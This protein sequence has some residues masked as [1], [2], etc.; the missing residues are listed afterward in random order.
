MRFAKNITPR[1]AYTVGLALIA[2]LVTL[3]LVGANVVVNR[4]EISAVQINLAGRQRMLSQRIAWTMSRLVSEELSSR[5]EQSLRNVLGACVDLM[6]RSHRALNARVLEEMNDV[7]GAGASCLSPDATSKTGLPAERFALAEPQSLAVFT[8]HAWEVALGLQSADATRTFLA[9]FEEPL[10]RLLEQLDR[11]TRDAQQK[12]VAQIELMLSINWILI[13]ALVL[14]ELVLIFQ[15][16]ARSVERSLLD[17]E[18]ANK[19]LRT[20]ENR[21]QDFA[22]TAAHQFWE[23]DA[24]HRFTWIDS[25]EPSARLRGVSCLVGRY[26]WDIN[27]VPDG[28]QHPDWESLRVAFDERQ[29]F[30]GFD[31]P[32]VDAAGLTRWWRLNGRPIYSEDNQFLGYRGTS[33]EI[34]RERETEAQLRVS[35]RMRA[36]GQLT[37]G[38]A[39]DFNNI[40]TVI[41]GS[42]DLIPL[43]ASEKERNKSVNA[44]KAGVFRGTSLVQRLL[45][46]GQNQYLHA[47]PVNVAIFL[48]ELEDLL[49]R[50][51]GEDFNVG[52]VLP[53]GNH[54][55]LADPNQLGDACLNIA[56]NARDAASPGGRLWIE[57]KVAEQKRIAELSGNVADSNRYFCISFRDNGP[58]ISSDMREKIFEPFFTSKGVGKGTG[59]GLSMVYGFVRQSNGYIDVQSVE[60]EGATFE[61]F[62]PMVSEQEETSDLPKNEKPL[63]FG[64]RALLV[65]DNDVLRGVT[66]RHLESMGMEVAESSGGAGALEQLEHGGPFDILILDI[67]LPGAIDG[68]EIFRRAS[69]T[70]PGIK[71]LFCSGLV[72]TDR[73]FGDP[74]DIPGFLLT[75]PF[76]LEEL[77]DAV[78]TVLAESDRTQSDKGSSRAY[79]DESAH[80]ADE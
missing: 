56:L 51:L 29:T 34:T 21:L 27:G 58:G 36:L 8:Q 2:M 14:G 77:A 16:M 61:I 78:R 39:H 15:P 38:V 1:R 13:I 32:V 25:S 41:Q 17:L 60:G 33:L 30:N 72:G 40:L 28:D 74:R 80:K 53:P 52:V 37:A 31:Y 63:S 70:D 24:N 42:A 23:T 55:I 79:P 6:E 65:E 11:D 10:T 62:L 22:S 19:L 46:F 3:Q 7:L 18:Q 49:Q 20:S 69:E 47:Q 44:I 26:I 75:K 67:V 4:Q 5:E 43:E 12:S 50:T 9:Q 48:H 68:V 66:R 71:V 59:L 57:A 76:G 54:Q 73:S 35:E 64:L 45:A